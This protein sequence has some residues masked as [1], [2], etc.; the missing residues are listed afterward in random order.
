MNPT[1]KSIPQLAPPRIGTELASGGLLLTP[2]EARW[3]RELVARLSIWHSRVPF[4]VP[5]GAPRAEFERAT[6]LEGM[7]QLGIAA[8]LALSVTEVGVEDYG[9]GEVVRC[10]MIG[11]KGGLPQPPEPNVIPAF[12]R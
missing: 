9:G 5:T 1:L 10:H 4:D 6:S 11:L 7:R 2:D 8:A 3:L 12:V